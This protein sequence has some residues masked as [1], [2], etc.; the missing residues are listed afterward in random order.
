M[1][2]E[3]KFAEFI[4]AYNDHDAD[5]MVQLLDPDVTEVQLDLIRSTGSGQVLGIMKAL[6]SAYS[7]L[8]VTGVEILASGDTF[9]T[10]KGTISGTH[11]GTLMA[12]DGITYPPSGNKVQAD[13][14]GFVELRAEKISR[15][16]LAY[17]VGLVFAQIRGEIQAPS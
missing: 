9:V 3:A 8:T 6:W 11:T 7:G 4:Q 17:N 13:V 1:S 14:L 2:A 16:L 12:P 15:L 5:K 10:Y